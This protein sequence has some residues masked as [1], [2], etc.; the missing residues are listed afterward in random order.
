MET[1]TATPGRSFAA[2]LLMVAALAVGCGTTEDPSDIESGSLA[3]AVRSEIERGP[4][5]F[6]VEI[7]PG[8]PRL[9]DEPQL[10]LA[11]RS[12]RGVRIE[13]PPFGEAL[14]DFLIR[15]FYE[16]IPDV[17]GDTQIIRQVY[18][19]EPTRAG[20]LTVAPIAVRFHDERAGWRRRGSHH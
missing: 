10:T 1:P 6:T 9:S 11:I 15:D 4:V 12:Q 18:T 16:P 2:A 13:K 17:D 14:G 7:S 3:D 19:L 5:K 8:K 20:K